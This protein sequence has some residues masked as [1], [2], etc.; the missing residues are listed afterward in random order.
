MFDDIDI[1]EIDTYE[2]EADDELLTMYNLEYGG[3]YIQHT[4]K[5]SDYTSDIDVTDLSVMSDIDE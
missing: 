1:P 3:E 5:L 4:E 2:S